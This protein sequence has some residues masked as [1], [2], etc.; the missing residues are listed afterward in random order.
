MT[1]STVADAL[2]RAAALIETQGL[3]VG[4]F[5]TVDGPLCMLGALRV[6][7]FGTVYPTRCEFDDPNPL[8]DEPDWPL[9]VDACDEL[10]RALGNACIPT[11][12]DRRNTATVVAKLRDAAQGARQRAGSA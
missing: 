3:A 9:Y 4:D 5:G 11:W 8:S 2:D 6:A 1:A 12:S 10:T 7:V